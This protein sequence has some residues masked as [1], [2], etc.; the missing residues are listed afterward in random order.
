MAF[1]R[2][3]LLAVFLTTPAVLGQPPLDRHGFPLPRGVIARLGDLRFAQSGEIHA[4]ALS[5]D[6]KVIATANQKRLFLW[7]ADSGRITRAIAAEGVNL[8]AFSRSGKLLAGG[9][10]QGGVTVWNLATGRRHWPTRNPEDRDRTTPA[11]LRFLDHD[12]LLA[13]RHEHGEVHLWDVARGTRARQWLARDKAGLLPAGHTF[14]DIALSPSGEQTAWLATPDRGVKEGRSVAFLFETRSGKL[15]RAV[16]GLRASA[17]RICL[18][19]EGQTLVL[20]PVLDGPKEDA[21]YAVV[22][23]ADG[24]VRFHCEYRWEHQYT[25]ECRAVFR[26]GTSLFTGDEAGLNRWDFATGKRLDAWPERSTLL[27]LS[28]DG[29]RA[30]VA[31]RAVAGLRRAPQA[32]AAERRLHD[33]AVAALPARRPPFH[34]HLV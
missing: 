25:P 30:V 6:G 19:D 17:R 8:L 20:G 3:A 21:A 31:E 18:V 27:A 2:I 32:R 5:P 23:V 13:V 34:R 28:G 9:I 26:N 22:N 15:L 29:K 14:T 1:R 4:L 7:D 10:G 33:L 12:R 16:K 11:A 24:K